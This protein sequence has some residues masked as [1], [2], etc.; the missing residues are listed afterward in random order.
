MSIVGLLSA[1]IDAIM[2]EDNRIAGSAVTKLTSTLSETETTGMLVLSTNGFGGLWQPVL[3]D[4][5]LLVG[6]EIIYASAR[7]SYSFFTLERGMEGT[8]AKQH[9]PGTLV[10][11][12]SGEASRQD[13]LR[14]GMTVR[15]AEGADLDVVGA[16]LGMHRCPGLNDTTYR[17]VIKAVAYLAKQPLH[18]FEQ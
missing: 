15:W 6:G 8:Q 16:N 5:R 12:I 2:G 11:D 3:Y 9:P 7:T 4:A 14:R 13:R 1:V 10:Y 17:E 18:A